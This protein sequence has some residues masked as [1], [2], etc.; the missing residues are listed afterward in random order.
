M[1]P[2]RIVLDRAVYN[3]DKCDAS[4]VRS[5]SVI[6]RYDGKVHRLQA[7]ILLEDMHDVIICGKGVIKQ[8]LILVIF[9]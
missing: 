2:V 9:C 3:F 8:T 6:R 7:G 1:R 5:R 4:S